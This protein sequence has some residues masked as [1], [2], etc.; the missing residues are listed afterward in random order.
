MWPWGHFGVAYILYSLYA[1]GR[2]GR[3]PR[4]EPAL[5]V[6]AGSQLAD[7][8]DKPLAWWFGILPSGRSLAHSL[9]FAAGLLV[10]VYAVGFALGRLETATAFAIAHLSH[11]LTDVP[12][13]AFLGYPHGTEFLVW[14]L[15]EQPTFR[16]HDR[17]FE[18]PAAVEVLV[19]PFTNPAIFFLS[20]WL[21][22]GTALALWYVDGCPGLEYVR[23]RIPA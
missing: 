7:L 18:P 20:E 8:I 2:F 21:L 22:F 16:F 19:G 13:R 10:V 6:L 1:R 14:P 17:L 23:A 5:A 11:I 3:P 9:L 12:P 15:L 4:P